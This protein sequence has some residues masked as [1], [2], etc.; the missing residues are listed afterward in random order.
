LMCWLWMHY[1]PPQG[2]SRRTQLIALALVIAILFPVISV[3][4]DFM[5]AQNPAE[6]DCCQRKAHA[7][8]NA[9]PTLHPVAVTLSLFLVELSS[10]SFQFAVQDNLLDLTAK[11]PAMASIQNRPPPAA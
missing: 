10:D 4:D 9:H 2:P 5:M 6:T 1:A 3:T 8:V 7:G 11:V